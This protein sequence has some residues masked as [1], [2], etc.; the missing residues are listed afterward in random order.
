MPEEES[1]SFKQ[2]FPVKFWNY[3]TIKNYS[4]NLYF[5]KK[6]GPN[7]DCKYKYSLGL[8]L[9]FASQFRFLGKKF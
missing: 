9:D 2:D 8:N 3:Y 6:H 7:L 4:L 5:E 1:K